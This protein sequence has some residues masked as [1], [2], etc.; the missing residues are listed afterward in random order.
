MRTSRRTALL[1]VSF[2]SAALLEENIAS[3]GLDSVF[4]T[5]VVDNSTDS[6]E[7]ASISSLAKSHG[8][9]LI[10]TGENLGFGAAVNLGAQRALEQ[11]ADALLL[12]NPD[13]RISVDDAQTLVARAT[14]EVIVA[15]KIVGLDGRTWFGGGYL[16]ERTGVVQHR[17]GARDWLTGACLAI[18]GIAWRRLGGFDERYF[19]YWEDVDLSVRW[20]AIGGQLEVL[21]SV[22]AVHAVGGTQ[23][24]NHSGKS[25]AYL[26]FNSRN[27]ILFCLERS[28]AVRALGIAL[29][30]PAYSWRLVQRARPATVREHLQAWSSVMRGAIAGV[31]ETVAQRTS[32]RVSRG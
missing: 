11:G 9:E 30:T 15:P 28:G 4:S 27:R 24:G 25:A 3:S 26:Y 2:N 18:D 20:R 1:V 8:W 31:R 13:A 22:E 12:L 6:R 23:L 19:L 29:R 7:A 32:A 10:A 16:D 17:D 21:D 5:I 14:S